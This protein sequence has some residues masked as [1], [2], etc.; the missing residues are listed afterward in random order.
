MHFLV[1]FPR[2]SPAFWSHNLCDQ[3]AGEEP[4]NEANEA[5]IGNS[6]IIVSSIVTIVPHKSITKL[7]NVKHCGGQPEQADTGTVLYH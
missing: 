3:K 1:S 2:S 7:E 4:G 5:T 6:K